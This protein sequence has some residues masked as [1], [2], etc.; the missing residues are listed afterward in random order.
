MKIQFLYIFLFLVTVS[1]Q[2]L[3]KKD[4]NQFVGQGAEDISSKDI[5][6]DSPGSDSGNIEGLSTVY[7]AHDSTVLTDHSKGILLKNLEWMKDQKTVQ[8]L[9][10]EGHC[11]HLGSEAYNIGLGRRRARAVERFLLS[12]G[13]K[14]QELSI[15]SYG[16]ERPLS[17]FD[18]SKNRRVNFVPV[19]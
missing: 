4:P 19:Y 3:K 11:D 15:V 12:Q 16:G 6:S 17:S 18:N 10:L 13:L 2:L 1:C 7:F 5:D 8:A 9:T 14:A